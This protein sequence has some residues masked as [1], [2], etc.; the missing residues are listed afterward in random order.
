[1]VY[2]D[3][4]GNIGFIAPGRVPVRKPE[5]DLKGVAP[6]PGWDARYDWA[7]FIP[8]DQLPRQFNPAS[9][10]IFTANN[11]IVAPDYPYFITSEWELP[12]R[13][14]RIGELLDARP[15]H[16]LD[17]FAAIQKDHISLAAQELLPILRK[18]N[19]RSDLSNAALDKLMKW[20]GEMDVDRIE[21]LV[22]TA[23]TRELSRQ[24]F[25]DELGTSLLEEYWG[26]GN[27][28]QAMVNVLKNT[29]GMAKWC[30]DATKPAVSVQSCDEVLSAS[31]EAAIDNL[32]NRF[33]KDMAQWHWGAAH[34]VRMAH[35]PFDK[36]E[37][38]AKFFNITMPIP[39]DT[40][41]INVGQT[42]FRNLKDPFV[43]TQ[44]PSMRVLYDLSNLENSR[45]IQTSG[46]SG[47]VL[48][49]LYRNYT[50]R[51]ANVEY[52]PMQ[53]KRESVEKNKLGTL[54]LVP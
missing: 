10:R 32:Q 50:K 52:L 47:N 36:V 45:F 9:Q 15:K 14:N 30:G 26:H 12:Y 51:W 4:E 53:T 54:T 25:A 20:N 38:L 22:F 24:I 3:I 41:T 37:T 33:G 16:N 35:R 13:A 42:N 39:G 18:A 21:P 11:K 34:V 40:F 1:M 46:Q 28:Y 2:A 23:W 5:N 49:P 17:S 8:F 44:A 29:N 7:G 19:P 43:S 27:Y 31:L 6:A 48:S